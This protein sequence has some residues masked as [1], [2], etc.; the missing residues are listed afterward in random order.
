MA[1][2]GGLGRGIGA[3]I[4]VQ[5]E[6]P[7]HGQLV[8]LDVSMIAPN[9][10]QPRQDFDEDRLRELADSIRALGVLQPVLVRPKGEG[11]ELIAGERRLRAAQMAGMKTIP[12][13]V[14]EVDDESSLTEA[15]VEN[16]QRA[17]L[18][19]IEEAMAY[20]QLIEDFDLTQEEVAERVGRSRPA[21]ANSLRLLGLPTSVQSLVRE[22]KLSA[23]HARAL[24]ALDDSGRQEV[25]AARAVA[26]G[27]SVRQLERAVKRE[28]RSGDAEQGDEGSG[29]ATGS[30]R[31]AALLELTELLEERLATRVRIRMP[32]SGPGRMEVDFADLADLE[33][34]A[35]LILQ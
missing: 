6:P 34:I 31:R 5:D 12:A 30:E 10:Q 20:K 11:F 27:W 35:K 21:I 28:L 3:L 19:P 22:G 9:P 33:R 24:A 4:P 13:I 26:R 1:R 14:R 25:L 18:D 23:G 17:D 2:R 32:G 7:S 29:E 8:E 16:V 15:L